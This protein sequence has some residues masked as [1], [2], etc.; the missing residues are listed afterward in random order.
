MRLCG[1]SDK[2]EHDRAARPAATSV[3]RPRLVLQRNVAHSDSLRD[4][5]FLE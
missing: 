3:G 5:W 2:A 4:G 1:M